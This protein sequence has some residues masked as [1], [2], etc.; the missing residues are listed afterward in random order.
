MRQ[1]QMLL[2]GAAGVLAWGLMIPANVASDQAVPPPSPANAEVAPEATESESNASKDGAA[3]DGAPVAL[4]TGT[5]RASCGLSCLD[6]PL[7]AR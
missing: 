4:E 2:I 1:A 6:V 5:S 7:A 3:A